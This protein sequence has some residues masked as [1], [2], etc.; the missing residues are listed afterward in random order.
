VTLE[1]LDLGEESERVDNTSWKHEDALTVFRLL[2][3]ASLR[4][5]AHLASEQ[6]QRHGV[7]C[8]RGKFT[9]QDLYRHMAAYHINH[10]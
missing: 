6:W 7:H 3:E 2:H 5:F 10:N 8:E 4:M 1:F 9:V